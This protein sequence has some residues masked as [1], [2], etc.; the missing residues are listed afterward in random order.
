MIIC[1]YCWSG[2]GTSWW[3][4]LTRRTVVGLGAGLATVRTGSPPAICSQ[5]PLE[6]Q[7]ECL[8]D[9]MSK[10]RPRLTEIRPPPFILRRPWWARC[11]LFDFFIFIILF[12]FYFKNSHTHFSK[13]SNPFHHFN[14]PSAIKSCC[15]ATCV[16]AAR[17]VMLDDDFHIEN[18]VTPLSLAR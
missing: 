9:G 1:T 10:H 13:I 7:P 12:N 2:T 3:G 4:L 17:S 8:I 15:R 11:S 18:L 6:H 14:T 16:G 5:P